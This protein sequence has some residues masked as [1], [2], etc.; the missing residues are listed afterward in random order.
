MPPWNSELT[1]SP[2]DPI[3]VF[4]VQSTPC[5]KQDKMWCMIISDGS[6]LFSP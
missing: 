1:K 6:Y 2:D 5:V 4:T 3:S